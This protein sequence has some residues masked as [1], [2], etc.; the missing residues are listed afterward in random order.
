MV[1]SS[2]ETLSFINDLSIEK[3]DFVDLCGESEW[4]VGTRGGSGDHAAM[5]FGDM[6]NIIHMGFCEITIEDVIPFPADYKLIILQSHQH[7]KKSGNAKQVFNEKVA[8]YEIAQALM[9]AQ[10]PDKRDRLV[11]FRDINA[12]CLGI[13]PHRIY[14]IL[15]RLP[16]RISRKETLDLVAEEDRSHI[17]TVFTTHAEPEEGYETR[18]VALYGLSEI[19]RARIFPHLIKSGY[20][21]EA[22][23][24]MNISHDGDR[25]SKMNGN[26]SRVAY[27]YG[28]SEKEMRELGRN[29]SNNDLNAA[30]HM[31]PGSYYCSTPLIDE[32]VDFSLTLEG[33]V[34]AQLSGAGLGGCIMVLVEKR[35]CRFIHKHFSGV[36][37]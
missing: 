4:F 24:L 5:K 26:G 17:E 14:D 27:R 1:V 11:Y 32:M 15:L 23:R 20:I 29:W 8:T 7:A 13:E 2:A 21:T 35:L 18:N 9:K 30:L 19:A 28:L 22:G 6:G 16:E 31:Q 12:E 33:V 10:L 37:L 34:G 25:V 3:K 36:F